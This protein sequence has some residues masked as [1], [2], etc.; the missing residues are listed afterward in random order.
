MLE[1]KFG[2]ETEVNL[3][4]KLGVKLVVKLGAKSLYWAS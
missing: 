1:L 2:A 3:E 4:V